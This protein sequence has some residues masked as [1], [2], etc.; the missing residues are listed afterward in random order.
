MTAT[1]DVAGAPSAAGVGGPFR[2]LVTRQDPSTRR[3]A[4]VGL[5]T[6]TGGSYEFSYLRHAVAAPGFRP[7]LG[8]SALNRRYRSERLFPLFAQRV[9][10]PRR[11]DRPRW[12]SSLGLEGDPEVMEILA[13]SGGR[14]EGD[15]LELLAVPVVD[16]DSSTRIS[17]LVHGVRHAGSFDDI[18]YLAVGDRL[19][20]VDDLGNPVNARALLVSGADGQRLG[21]VPDPLVEFVRHVGDRGDVDVRVLRVNPVELGSHQRLLVELSG[22]ADPHAAPLAAVGLETAG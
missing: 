13:R 19:R 7:L 12:L 1:A 14:R 4:E 16:D 11:P 10:D 9:M 22:R 5:L 8:F 20:L 3:Y 2:L 6:C 21:W 15:H 17:F 18:G